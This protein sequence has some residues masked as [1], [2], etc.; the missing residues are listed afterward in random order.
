MKIVIENCTGVSPRTPPGRLPPQG[1]QTAKN[2][3][4]RRK[5]LRPLR[6][7]GSLAVRLP[8]GTETI[9]KWGETLSQREWFAWPTEVDVCRGQLAGDDLEWTIF[10]G[11]GYPKITNA[12]LHGY[13]E[14]PEDPPDDPPDDPPEEPPT[15]GSRTI[16]ADD[17][18]TSGYVRGDGVYSPI[19]VTLVIT[20]LEEAFALASGPVAISGGG[21]VSDMTSLSGLNGAI[22]GS[23]VSLAAFESAV[24]AASPAG[25]TVKFEPSYQ[26]RVLKIIS[27]TH[28]G[29]HEDFSLAA[30]FVVT[31]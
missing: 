2:V 4:V 26:G 24:V 11:D 16:D 21:I 5:T 18:S 12:N 8:A 30:P 23:H 17:F 28:I 3:D 10:T 7:A 15:G 13:G 20:S 25:Y 9:Y 22:T 6:S 19:W 14:P 31:W 27:P 29:V 1:A